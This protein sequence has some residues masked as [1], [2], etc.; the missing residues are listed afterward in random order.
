ELMFQDLEFD[1]RFCGFWAGAGTVKFQPL[2]PE[3]GGVRWTIQA[4][5]T[6]PQGGSGK[7]GIE[8]LGRGLQPLIDRFGTDFKGL[9]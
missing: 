3:D 4:E 6:E 7:N 2:D 1:T 5:A 9:Y 8:I